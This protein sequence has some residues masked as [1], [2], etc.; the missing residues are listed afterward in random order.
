[1]NLRVSI[2]NI[3]FLN[4]MGHIFFDGRVSD[5][6]IV[7]RDIHRVSFDQRHLTVHSTR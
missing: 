4:K 5:D 3:T 6:E 1:M 2:L 7:F